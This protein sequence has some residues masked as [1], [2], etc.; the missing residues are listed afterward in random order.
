MPDNII[1]LLPPFLASRT[2]LAILTTFFIAFALLVFHPSSP[3]S[4]FTPSISPLSPFSSNHGAFPT[5]DEEYE[6]DPSVHDAAHNQSRPKRIAIVGAGAS[7][8]SAAWFMRRA[9]RIIEERLGKEEGEVLGEIVIF[10]KEDRV[11]GSE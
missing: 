1:M 7:G 10:D 9:G 3:A 11:G 5:F 2:R 4:T 6:Y 8:S